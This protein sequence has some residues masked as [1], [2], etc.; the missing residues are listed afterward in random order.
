MH[1]VQMAWN[2]LFP[3]FLKQNDGNDEYFYGCP[4]KIYRIKHEKGDENC[5]QFFS[6][7]IKQINESEVEW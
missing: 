1:S 6:L 7:K 3:K 2:F 4:S 5:Q